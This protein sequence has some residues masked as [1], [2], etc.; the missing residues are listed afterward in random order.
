MGP[1]AM[2]AGGGRA[3]GAAG[4]KPGAHSRLHQQEGIH[5]A[6]NTY[7]LGT[8]TLWKETGESIDLNFR[9]TAGATTFTLGAYHQAFDNYIYADTLDRLEDFRLIRYT[10]ADATFTGVD[11]EVRHQFSPDFGA[12]IFDYVR[13]KL[14][15]DL[16]NLPPIP[17]GRLGG[18][19]DG[20]WGGLSADV[21]HYHIFEQGRIASFETRTPG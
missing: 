17:A 14:K 11:G 9:K 13:V 6:T 5:L 10:A 7:K 3:R 12:S 1:E 2:E 19:A 21:E 4:R 18:R 15:N 8:A 16:G 20:K